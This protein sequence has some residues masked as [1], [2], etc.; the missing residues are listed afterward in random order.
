MENV[1]LTILN[2]GSYKLFDPRRC[3]AAEGLAEQ[4]LMCRSPQGLW[5][6]CL[7][8]LMRLTNHRAIPEVPEVSSLSIPTNS[9]WWISFLFM[10]CEVAHANMEQKRASVPLLAKEWLSRDPV[11]RAVR[12]HTLGYRS[13]WAEG[14]ESILNIHDFAQNLQGE[15][16]K[17][18]PLRKNADVSSSAASILL[19]RLDQGLQLPVISV[20]HSIRG[21][22]SRR[23]CPKNFGHRN[24]RSQ[25]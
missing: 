8:N 10:I 4:R 9:L 11:S 5:R 1:R 23:Y 21:L 24:V 18:R 22:R 13:D 17:S 3:M 15:L 6:L 19:V 16:Q 2:A 7:Y 14:T 20:I 12:I 25:I